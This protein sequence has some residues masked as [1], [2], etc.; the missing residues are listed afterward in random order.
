[1]NQQEIREL[2][3]EQL[4][5]VQTLRIVQVQLLAESERD[6]ETKRYFRQQ[7]DA[8]WKQYNA[9]SQQLIDR[10]KTIAQSHETLPWFISN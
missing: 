10:Y 8:A 2:L 6:A 3:E 7:A 5:C 1:M 4:H 9:I